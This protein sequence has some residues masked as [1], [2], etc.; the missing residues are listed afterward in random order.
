MAPALGSQLV[1]GVARSA[2]V[3]VGVSGPAQI[4]DPYA[5]VRRIEVE[6]FVAG[7]TNVVLVCSLASVL[8]R[9]SALRDLAVPSDQRIPDIASETGSGGVI[10]LAQRIYLQTLLLNIQIVSAEAASAHSVALLQ[11][12]CRK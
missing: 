7:S 5:Q 9:S 2:E 12:I 8:T 1:A 11:T 6:P 4:V 3:V 10:G